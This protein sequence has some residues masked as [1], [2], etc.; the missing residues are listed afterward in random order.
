MLSLDSD[1]FFI[2]EQILF[3]FG[4][5]KLEQR[6]H[7]LPNQFFIRPARQN[8]TPLL[9][10]LSQKKLLLLVN[11]NCGCLIFLAQKKCSQIVW[12]HTTSIF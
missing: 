3:S 1:S 12:F 2:Y 7:F 5:I 8:A 4:D 10:Q 9:E 6:I 11:N